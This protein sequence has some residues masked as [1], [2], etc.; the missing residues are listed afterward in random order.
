MYFIINVGSIESLKHDKINDESHNSL[1]DA[2]CSPPNDASPQEYK[3]YIGKLKQL[4]EDYFSCATN[5]ME[6]FSRN[7]A[8]SELTN[9]RKERRATRKEVYDM[10]AL[11][12]NKLKEADEDVLSNIPSRSVSRMSQT[13]IAE[14]FAVETSVDLTR[15]EIDHSVVDTL[16]DMVGKNLN[17]S[18]IENSCS[19]TVGF[20][21]VS[22]SD[23]QFTER[24]AS[25]AQ[26][27]N[28]S[29]F[30]SRREE[31]SLFQP[32]SL[33]NSTAVSN[34]QKPLL[35]HQLHGAAAS[36]YYRQQGNHDNLH[37]TTGRQEFSQ[38]LGTVGRGA[39]IQGECGSGTHATGMYNTVPQVQIPLSN[40]AMSCGIQPISQGYYSGNN[41]AS[42]HYMPPPVSTAQY[43]YPNHSG[44]PPL[45]RCVPSNDFQLNNNAL[46]NKLAKEKLFEQTKT[47]SGQPHRYRGWIAELFQKIG[48]KRRRYID[49]TKHPLAHNYSVKKNGHVFAHHH[50]C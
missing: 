43:Q 49:E 42:N 30:Q 4:S 22:N 38:P 13:E 27:L 50:L 10:I 35:S 36:G 39:I 17:F 1:E 28:Q 46:A 8:L 15:N 19:N 26:N 23:S 18:Q 16:G 2:L 21:Q 34:T 3:S 44:P 40:V 33:N 5:V 14:E 32:I 31:K 20:V 9:L 6:F 24:L 12:N 48:C 7:S 29:E 45:P 47:F 41:Q 11:L 25:Q 37:S